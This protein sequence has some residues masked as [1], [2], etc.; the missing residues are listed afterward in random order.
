MS[1]RNCIEYLC[2]DII[3]TNMRNTYILSD[4]IKMVSKSMISSNEKMGIIENLVCDN[5][6][7]D[8][9]QKHI[10]HN[11]NEE[12]IF[13][14]LSINL[15]VKDNKLILINSNE[16]FKMDFNSS[17]QFDMKTAPHIVHSCVSSNIAKK[18]MFNHE[19]QT[20]TRGNILS[21]II[22]FIKDQ[23]RRFVLLAE[24]NVILTDIDKMRIFGYYILKTLFTVDSNSFFVKS[25]GDIDSVIGDHIIRSDSS[26]LSIMQDIVDDKSHLYQIKKEIFETKKHFNSLFNVILIKINDIEKQL[27]HCCNIYL[28]DKMLIDPSHKQLL[29]VIKTNRGSIKGFHNVWS[30]VVHLAKT[31]KPFEEL[32]TILFDDVTHLEQKIRQLSESIE[33]LNRHGKICDLTCDNTNANDIKQ[34]IFGYTDSQDINEIS[35]SICRSFISASL[36]KDNIISDQITTIMVSIKSL[37]DFSYQHKDISLFIAGLKD[38]SKD[39]E[40]YQYLEMFM[41][42]TKDTLNSLFI[43]SD[44]IN[45][46]DVTIVL[47]N[48]YPFLSKFIVCQIIDTYFYRTNIC[49]I[50]ID[51]SEYVSGLSVLDVLS[52]DSI[53]QYN[54]IVSK[55]P[56]TSKIEF[57][58]DDVLYEH[59][60][61]NLNLHKRL[62]EYMRNFISSDQYLSFQLMLL[63][64]TIHYVRDVIGIT[65]AV[66]GTPSEFHIKGGFCRDII[67]KFF[68]EGECANNENN[69]N[70]KLFRKSVKDID[71]AMNIDPEI[72]TFYLCMIASTK[73]KYPPIKRWNNAEKTEKG[74]NI[75]VWSVKLM[76]EYDPMEFVHFRT[77]EYD[78]ITSEVIATDIY[79]SLEDDLRRDIP[80][81]SFR[82][83]DMIIVDYFN[84]IGMMNNGDFSMRTP[85]KSSNAYIKTKLGIF[86]PIDIVL[87]NINHKIHVESAERIIRL[88]KFISPPFDSHFAF[89]YDSDNGL[90]NKINRYGFK[91]HKDL[92]NLY[93]CP[94]TPDEI[95]S[96]REIHKYIKFWLEGG[97][98]SNVFKSVENIAKCYPHKFFRLMNE[99]GILN[100]LFENNYNVDLSLDYSMKLEQLMLN[101]N[102]KLNLPYA[103]LGLG[104]KNKDTL[105]KHMKLL[106]LSNETHVL[107]IYFHKY[108]DTL[109]DILRDNNDREK[110]VFDMLSESTGSFLFVHVMNLL[111]IFGYSFNTIDN[112]RYVTFLITNKIHDKMNACIIATITNYSTIILMRSNNINILDDKYKK[113]FDFK[114]NIELVN[115]ITRTLG[116]PGV[117]DT[118][119]ISDLEL[120]FKNTNKPK[121][122]REF[123]RTNTSDM[124][125]LLVTHKNTELVFV[126]IIEYINELE[127]KLCPDN[128]YDHK[129]NITIIL[130][131]I[132]DLVKILEQIMYFNGKLND[133][134]NNIKEKLQEKKLLILPIDVYNEIGYTFDKS[135]NMT[136]YDN[137]AIYKS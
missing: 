133:K 103:I 5:I 20:H 45:K 69:Q 120:L 118:A 11:I 130:D 77:D 14:D 15:S 132:F 72:F 60:W 85:P 59:Q 2:S 108:A 49:K 110:I 96:L 16:T 24:N 92:I 36:K 106:G 26:H 97:I 55:L 13:G 54:I 123:L 111:K 75:S 109:F 22:L 90:F 116:V 89:D 4:L 33:A 86:E 44:L 101:T 8:V 134:V 88:F 112:N 105:I 25:V 73:Y 95:R 3:F 66:N 117:N 43:N 87:S 57:Y 18:L 35:S 104:A 93:Q 128:P 81:P 28:Q 67:L 68:S 10:D 119:L 107:A 122:I 27:T 99:F 113:W 135:M 1:L 125:D 38:V 84:I 78:P 21:S 7:D 58:K 94:T 56:I 17:I 91:I 136:I 61:S 29:H 31:C 115:M 62:T 39:T 80:W 83:N 41:L 52:L 137:Y 74:K 76:D 9:L 82:L 127:N 63:Y 48:L 30:T 102:T 51:V 34:N 12:L 79:S 124:K 42:E 46:D 6:S 98:L 23:K 47:T 32:I 50:L 40:H 65:H 126:K 100:V 37:F 131:R 129:K 53:E 70:R 71:I 19:K 121:T 64:D 114:L